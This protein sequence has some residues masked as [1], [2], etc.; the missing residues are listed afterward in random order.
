MA[1]KLEEITG[2][3]RSIEAIGRAGKRWEYGFK[4]LARVFAFLSAAYLL[5]NN[6]VSAS[7]CLSTS[8]LSFHLGGKA[9][10]SYESLS[11]AREDRIRI[12][13]WRNNGRSI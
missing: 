4:S 13:G 6:Y 2:E 9:R 10:E 3:E 1:E 7:I 11:K 8:A 5:D 12:E